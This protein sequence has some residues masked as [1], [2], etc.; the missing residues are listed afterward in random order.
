MWTAL[1]LIFLIL[2]L[3]VDALK[4]NAGY[5]VLHYYKSLNEFIFI[6]FHPIWLSGDTIFI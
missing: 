2:Y 6:K 5:Y 4:K 3:L 1:S